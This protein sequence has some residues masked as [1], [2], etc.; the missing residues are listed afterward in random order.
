[1]RMTLNAHPNPGPAARVARCCLGIGLVALGAWL[2]VRP[3]T[4]LTALLATVAVAGA[5]LAVALVA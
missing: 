1:M 4:S 5:V 3:L 2:I